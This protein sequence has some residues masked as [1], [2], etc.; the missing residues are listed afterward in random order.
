MDIQTGDYSAEIQA[1][2]ALLQDCRCCPHACHADRIAGNTGYCGITSEIPVA[3][4]V[5]HFG[6]EPCISGEQG[7]CNVFF[8]SCNL[9]CVYCQNHQISRSAASKYS[10]L[11][12]ILNTI[13][14]CLDQGCQAVGFVSPS[15]LIPQI[16][17]LM[18]GLKE[19]GRDPV[20]VYNSNGY[21]DVS[22]LRLL[23]GLIDVYLPDFKYRDGKIAE[24]YSGCAD[25]PEKAAAALREM[26]RQ[27]GSTLITD[28]NGLARSGLIIRHLVLPGNLENSKVVLQY[29]AEELSVNIHI[30]LMAQYYPD[31]DAYRFPE[32][33]RT[34]SAE[35]YAAIVSEFETL[36]FRKGWIQDLSSQETYRPD[37]ESNNP[38]Q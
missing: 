32:I 8:A 23:E 28:E 9:H 1:V 30:S 16:I 10:G 20:Y 24:R 11:T 15:H 5:P 19:R 6:E 3:A 36:G 21:D 22:M 35:E 33:N 12:E 26:Y 31:A 17:Q 27:K 38:F 14:A 4:I 2:R 29:I 25:Y 37:F 7:I 34:L 13:E 18:T